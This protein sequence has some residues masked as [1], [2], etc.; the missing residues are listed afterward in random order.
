MYDVLEQMHTLFQANMVGD[1]KVNL[2]QIGAYS[3]TYN[4]NS[5]YGD[6]A[7]IL[8]EPGDE[9]MNIST[10]GNHLIKFYSVRVYIIMLL[11]DPRQ[12]QIQTSRIN[13]GKT[14][15]EYTNEMIRLLGTDKLLSGKVRLQSDRFKIEQ[16]TDR[17]GRQAKVIKLQYMDDLIP[18][19]S[20]T[21]N[22]SDMIKQI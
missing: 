13:Q 16:M 3:D 5:R 7:M 17:E 10:W 21:I 11:N 8:L 6:L 15:N 18:Y 22:Q 1:F 19:A 20:Q 14:L 9:D 12:A 2:I 4:N